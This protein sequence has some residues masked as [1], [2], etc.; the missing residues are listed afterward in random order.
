M[1]QNSDANLKDVHWTYPTP[2]T[3][4]FPTA[5]LDYNMRNNLR[6]F[7]A[8][9][10][11]KTSQQNY[12]VPPLPGSLYSKYGGTGNFK[13]FTLGLG[14]DWTMTSTLLN[15]FRAGYLY[16]SVTYG[17]DLNP[18]WLTQPSINFAYGASGLELNNLPVGTYYPVF[19]ASDNVT[20]AEGRAQ[21]Q[22]RLLI[23]PRARPL[24]QFTGWIPVH[25]YGDR[26]Q[27][28]CGSGSS[29]ITLP[30]TSRTLPPPM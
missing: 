12:D 13:Y 10:M 15:S 25:R 20:L 9:N 5:R 4:Y 6:L 22:L 3:Q 21:H 16:N 26:P 14:V 7:L 30:R 1:T 28:S 19:N 11:T 27:R 23:L 17:Y 29:R 2:L 18:A 24:L 8:W